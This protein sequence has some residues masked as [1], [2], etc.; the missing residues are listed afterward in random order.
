MT[1]SG[2]QRSWRDALLLYVDRRVLA[3]LCLG[4]SAGL[5]FLL[6]FSTLSAWLR[7]AG[8]SRT[9]IGFLSWVGIAYAIKVLWAPFVDRLTLPFL[10]K[11]FGRRRS[12][13]VVAMVGIA[14]GLA[15]MAFT[16]P[17]TDLA[18][19]AAL[20]LVVAF[21]SATQDV[22]IDAFRI[23][24]GGT[25]IQG[26]LAAS[27]QL[28]YRIALLVAGAGALYIAEFESW[29]AAYLTMAALTSVGLV[30]A[31]MVREPAIVM[32]IGSEAREARVLAFLEGKGH[33]P[34]I[35]RL[36][37]AW[38]VG[39]VI[40]PFVDFFERNGAFAL[41]ILAF[42]G[43]FRVADITMGVMAYPFYIDLG[44]D[45]TEIANIIKIYGF[46]MTIAGALI[47]GALV[48][49]YGTLRPLLLSSI[50]IAA[51]NILFAAL[52]GW[53]RDPWLLTLVISADNISAGIAGSVFIAYLSGLTNIAYT[54]T[55]YALFTS[56][57][58]LPGKFLGGF[59]GLV[60]DAV[61]YETFFMFTAA[62]GLPSALLVLILMRRER[63][64]TMKAPIAPTRLKP[65]S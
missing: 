3:L 53:G 20:A 59:S 23:E 14:A 46:A 13:M 57:M 9:A 5:P 37:A 42:I 50:L 21:S 41:V 63:R 55:Q 52:A 10:S 28:G 48:A 43:V 45:K 31:L 25:D 11:R 22:A 47:G 49:R 24:Q 61:G 39:A 17:R 7:E 62:A 51:T 65:H 54:A 32:G 27:Y 56:L 26:A 38:L 4:F 12:W 36:P 19:I 6:V 58:A 33:W 1:G 15:G 40:G 35:I 8:V 34:S 60:V 18:S 30:T 64:L 16:D 2:P 44:F 29:R